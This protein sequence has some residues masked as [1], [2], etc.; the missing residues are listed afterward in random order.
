MWSARKNHA[1]SLKKGPTVNPRDET[2]GYIVTEGT[3]SNMINYRPH[4]AEGK[5]PT[6]DTQ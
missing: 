1:W 4:V 3:L 6:V 2:L 5:L